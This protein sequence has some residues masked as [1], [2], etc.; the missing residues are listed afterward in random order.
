MEEKR[1]Q[2]RAL[3]LVEATIADANG[4]TWHPIVLLDVSDIGIAF[5]HAQSIERGTTR[6]L[7]FRLP[8]NPSHHDAVVTI[9]HSSTAGVPSGYRVGAKFTAA[10]TETKGAI[11]T[12]TSQGAQ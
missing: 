12:F 11:A 1:A 7:R 5:A 3:M 4:E 10:S 9:V 6:M 2:T 8:G